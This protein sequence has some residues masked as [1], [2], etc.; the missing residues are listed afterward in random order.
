MWLGTLIPWISSVL[1]V[2]LAPFPYINLAPLSFVFSGLV[3]G[4]GLYRFR[5]IDIAPVARNTLIQNMNDG[6]L[7]L[8]A[9]DRVVDIN[10]A[11]QKLIGMDANQAIGQPE[12]DVLRTCC[13]FLD[14]IQDGK[15]TQDE[16]MIQVGESP[17]YFDL[18]IT[19]LL[20]RDGRMLVLRDITERIQAETETREANQHLSTKLLEVEALEVQLREQAIRDP[21]TS[22][23]NRRYL[24]EYLA[25]ELARSDR[26]NVLMSVIM[27]DIDCFKK[28]NDTYGHATGDLMLQALSEMLRCNIRLEDV[29]F[30]YGGEEFVV[31]LPE[32]DIT[33]AFKRADELR[34]KFEE[35]V[36]IVDEHRVFATFSAGVA[37]YPQH[38]ASDIEILQA[39]DTALYKAKSAG[40]NCVMV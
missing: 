29:A 30:R 31:V 18:S 22:L 39:A 32:T 19:P 15:S 3:I 23:Y 2:F 5:L 8:D 26:K 35:L 11:M 4:W 13:G 14:V 36:V 6:M 10:P 37:N 38:G 16:I 33:S 25:K 28:L 17:H 9:H 7:V 40:R 24:T 27:I 34:L 1:D 21:L 12:T 20:D